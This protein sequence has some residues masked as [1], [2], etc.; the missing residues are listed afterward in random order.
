MGEVYKVPVLLPVQPEGGYLV[1][2]PALPELVTEGE[3][4]ERALEN[5]RDALEAVLELYQDLGKPLPATLRQDPQA[6]AIWF[7]EVIARP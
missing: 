7:E 2:S 5:L 3:T 4:V 6:P 1:T